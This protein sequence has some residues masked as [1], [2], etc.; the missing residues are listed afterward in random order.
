MKLLLKL[1]MLLLLFGVSATAALAQ[2]DDVYYD[3]ERNNNRTYTERRQVQPKTTPAQTEEYVDENYDEEEYD[4]Y[5]TSR[6]RRFHRPYAGFNYFDPVY[7]DAYYYDAF[8]RPG[9]AVLIYDDP[10][11]YYG[12]NRMSRFNRWNG[13]AYGGWNRFNRMNSWNSWGNY[14]PYCMWSNPG[15]SFGFNRWNSFGMNNWNSFG[16]GNPYWANSGWFNTPTW[17]NNN[18]YNNNNY[19]TN[20]Q[21]ENNRNIYNGPRTGGGGVGTQPGLDNPNGRAPRFTNGPDI[22]SNPGTVRPD[23][24]GGR[25]LDEAPSYDRDRTV[26]G[27]GNPRVTTDPNREVL[28]TPNSTDRYRDARENLNRP[29]NETRRPETADPFSGGRRIDNTNGGVRTNTDDRQN[30]RPNTTQENIRPRSY[31]PAPR[32][33][34]NN[35]LERSRTYTPDR[36][37]ERSRSNPAPG[38][39]NT[40]R[41]NTPSNSGS[42]RPN[43]DSGRSNSFDS[44]RSNTAP[45]SIDSGSSRPSGGSSSP[46]SSGSS[47][48][49]GRSS[50]SGGR[51][52]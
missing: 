9:V 48:S 24:S 14:D 51:Q 6:I 37:Y 38:S 39:Y 11:G 20:N 18:Y 15:L 41:N 4:Y 22:K 25:K 29:S 45:R 8:A 33:T 34:D 3:P 50:S 7:V 16:F 26:P 2:Y 32:S 47:S 12:F 43:Y 21:G 1:S 36:S 23:Y 49:G 13:W 19:Y 40:P 42:A 10:F 28:G 27:N 46:S 35:S 44:G 31:E 17:G 30:L 5:Y 52:N